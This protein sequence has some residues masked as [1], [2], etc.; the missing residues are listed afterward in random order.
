MSVLN[1]GH[2]E[3]RKTFEFLLC[4]TIS[5]SLIFF[6]LPVSLL[7]SLTDNFIRLFNFE[8]RKER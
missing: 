5:F 3:K 1:R 4:A 2:L 6:F 7:S 8:K